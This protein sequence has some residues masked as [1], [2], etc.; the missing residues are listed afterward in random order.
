MTVGARRRGRGL[1]AAFW[2]AVWPACAQETSSATAT[3]SDIR[4]EVQSGVARRTTALRKTPFRD[5]ASLAVL[6][7]GDAVEIRHR[8]GGWYKVS[9]AAT[10]GWVRMLDISRTQSTADRLDLAAV[11]ALAS[12]RAGTGQIVSTTGIRGLGEEAL[13]LARFDAAGLATLE[14]F[15]VRPG[16]LKRFARNGKL[17]ARTVE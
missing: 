4:S 2:L 14:T 8:K 12:G 15:T 9:S 16:A 7:A 5:A 10:V 17:T 1:C 3:Q 6:A 13:K 11:A